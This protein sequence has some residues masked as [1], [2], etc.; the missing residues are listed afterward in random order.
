MVGILTEEDRN[1]I[2]SEGV[3]TQSILRLLVTEK[4]AELTEDGEET[5]SLPSLKEILDLVSDSSNTNNGLISQVISIVSNL[6]FPDN[7]NLIL[8]ILDIVTSLN[9][10]SDTLSPDLEQRLTFI[11]SK[12]TLNENLLRFI[13]VNPPPVVIQR[14]DAIDEKLVEILSKLEEEP[15][16][17]PEDEPK[18]EETNYVLDGDIFSDIAIFLEE[19]YTAT[20]KIR[21][22]TFDQGT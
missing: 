21:T 10:S 22:D 11:V 9:D 2:N 13:R 20:V 7:I 17:P 1:F 19:G 3:E 18:I 14:F 4:F 16:E 8:D 6:I 5:L 12:L 15:T